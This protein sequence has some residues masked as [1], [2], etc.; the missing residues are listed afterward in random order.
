MILDEITQDSLIDSK[1]KGAELSLSGE[2][3]VLSKWNT[4]PTYLL[5]TITGQT[6]NT[7]PALLTESVVENMIPLHV[8]NK[9]L[10]LCNEFTGQLTLFD[11]RD[12]KPVKCVNGKPSRYLLVKLYS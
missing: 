3:L 4:L 6:T 9:L 2:E 5:D 8:D 11:T 1:L 7:I 10:A 12:C